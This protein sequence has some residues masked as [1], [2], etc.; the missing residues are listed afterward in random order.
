LKDL[1]AV[2]RRFA[3]AIVRQE[4]I[5]ST[6]LLRALG[7]VQRER[8]LGKGPWRLRS[9]VPSYWSTLDSDPVHIYEDVLVAL[10]ERRGIDNGLPSLWAKM[11]NLLDIK[12]RAC[13]VQ[14]GCGTGYYSAI[15]SH[16][17]GPKGKVIAIDCEKSFVEKARRNLRGQG[18]VEVV[19][20]DGREHLGVSADVVVVHAGF[21][22]AH[23]VW[24]N[25]LRLNGTL[26][27]PITNRHGQGTVFKITRSDA[28]YRAEA[29]GPIQI[30]ASPRDSVVLDN[31]RLLRWWEARSQVRSLRL[32]AH[33][34][35]RTC[36]L[37]R[38]GACLSTRSVAKKAK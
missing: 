23:R 7:T 14:I 6:R 3:Q 5:S 30:M 21:S 33:A 9:V 19:H 15:L 12:E 11:F 32:D 26:L 25:A 27:V 24:L 22:H 36:W 20:R 16:L 29:V 28:Q 38:Q 1:V 17:V 31:K 35:D 34:R 37:H 8:F 18:N 2:R 10:D 4:G 13:V